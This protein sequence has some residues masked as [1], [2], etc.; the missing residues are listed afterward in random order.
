MMTPKQLRRLVAG[1]EPEQSL[2]AEFEMA[3]RVTEAARVPS[4]QIYRAI[5]AANRAGES[6]AK[7]SGAIRAVIPGGD[8]EPKLQFIEGVANDD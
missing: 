3:L 1:F 8:V 4:T 7:Q 6:F 5:V 2:T